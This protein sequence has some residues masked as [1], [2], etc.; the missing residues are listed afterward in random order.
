MNP[1]E[2]LC[3]VVV[4]YIKQIRAFSLQL[5]QQKEVQVWVKRIQKALSVLALNCQDHKLFTVEH[6]ATLLWPSVSQF[7]SSA[8]R[9]VV[10]VGEQC[11]CLKTGTF[12]VPSPSHF[13]SRQIP[14]GWLGKGILPQVFFNEPPAIKFPLVFQYL[15]TIFSEHQ[16]EEGQ[17]FF[18]FLQT[19]F[20]YCLTGLNLHH[21]L[22]FLVGKGGNG[23]SMFTSMLQ[24]VLNGDD[25]DLSSASGAAPSSFTPQ[26][27]YSGGDFEACQKGLV[28]P[29]GKH[30]VLQSSSNSSNTHTAQLNNL[31][32]TRIA[33]IDELNSEDFLDKSL[34]KRLT[35]G[36]PLELC[37]PYDKHEFFVTHPCHS[38]IVTCN[39]LPYMSSLDSEQKAVDKAGS[40]SRNIAF[41]GSRQQ[42]AVQDPQAINKLVKQ[43]DFKEQVLFWLIK[44][45]MKFNQQGLIFP[46][47]VADSRE[48]YWME[49]NIVASFLDN[50]SER[51]PTEDPSF[52]MDIDAAI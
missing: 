13:V 24:S 41:Y 28:Q 51:M 39:S 5:E 7:D 9:N 52:P 27:R 48:Q 25:T 20:G 45:A 43:R 44:G 32:G 11:I 4:N 34:I 8:A 36:D 21:Y 16:G 46:E 23:K 40:L 33:L 31:V 35:G 12:L 22:V 6:L 18:T 37:F 15:K 42:T 29:L 49:N 26:P 14:T 47:C 30:A 1:S 10:V 17:V 38:L 3:M 50:H 19:L 2:R